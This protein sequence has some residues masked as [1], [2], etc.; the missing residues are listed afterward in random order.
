VKGRTPWT[1]AQREAASQRM[2]AI[3]ASRGGKTNFMLGHTSNGKGPMATQKHW[4]QTPEGR[5]RMA[6]IQ[7]KAARARKEARMHLNGHSVEMVPPQ[8]P[9][10]LKHAR[11]FAKDTVKQ[12][13]IAGAK[14][15]LREVEAERETL[16]I[17]IRS[18]EGAVKSA[19][20]DAGK[21]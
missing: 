11:G 10:L 19:V 6:Q 18:G 17:F 12:F 4:T 9:L 13:A 1:A 2:K 15:R 14:Q 8:A 21:K 16:L 3:I 5:K 7:K 20:R